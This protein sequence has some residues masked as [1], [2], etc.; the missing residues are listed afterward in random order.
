MKGTRINSQT[1]IESLNTAA[2]ESIPQRKPVEKENTTKHW[3]NSD[4]QNSVM[5]RKVMFCI[6]KNNPT[7]KNFMNCKRA[8]AMVK[9]T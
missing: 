4:C 3:W 7:V 6:Y 5:K 8:D 9:Q 2:S 1:K